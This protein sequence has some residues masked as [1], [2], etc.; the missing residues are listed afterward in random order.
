MNMWIIF[1]LFCRRHGLEHLFSGDMFV[2][3][4]VFIGKHRTF[5]MLIGSLSPLNIS[6][7]KIFIFKRLNILLS[8]VSIGAGNISLFDILNLSL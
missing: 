7:T 6:L 8:E 3:K 5:K 1:C 2:L 4:Q